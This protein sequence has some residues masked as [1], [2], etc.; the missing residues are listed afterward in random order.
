RGLRAVRYHGDCHPAAKAKR[1]RVA[2][3]TG[4]PCSSARQPSPRKSRPRR[5]MSV[6]RRTDEKKFSASADVEIRPR[7]AAAQAPIL[8]M[9]AIGFTSWIMTGFFR[10]NGRGHGELWIGN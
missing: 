10:T 7:T 5:L 2:F 8:R 6:L 3:H 1:E 4:R 9:T